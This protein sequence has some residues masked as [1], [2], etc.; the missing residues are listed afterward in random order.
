MESVR[1]ERPSI[2]SLK[3]E[4]L[5]SVDMHFHTNHSDSPTSVLDAIKLAGR[6][7]IGVAITDHN[8]ISGSLEACRISREVLI[9]PGL[10]VS[11][12]DGPHILVYFRSTDDMQHFYKRHVEGEKRK[13]PYLAIYLR[14]EDIVE[15]ARDYNSLVVAAHPY[16]YLLFNKGLQKCI[17][18]DWLP[19]EL[20][21]EFDGI[22]AISGGMGR[23]QNLKATR[24]AQ[25]Y[26]KAITG[27]T[28][29]HLIWDLGKVVTCSPSETVDGFLEDIVKKRNLVVG[30]EKNLG[31]KG[32]MGAVVMTKY[33][34][35]AI[36]SMR[37][38]YE[39][40]MPRIVRSL[41]KVAKGKG[42][43]KDV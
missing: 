3:E 14:T 19:Q 39:Q 25:Q 37:V 7:G 11:A 24:L 13:S 20:I 43:S 41:K 42:R 5:R 2:R 32:V 31:H 33:L 1:F 6:K 18:A 9:I 17:D 12:A 22:E 26:R 23:E 21:H 29:G 40:N 30:M 35:Y 16:G 38:H 10:E 4:G 15:K 36:P 27:G 34:R 8:T 28:D